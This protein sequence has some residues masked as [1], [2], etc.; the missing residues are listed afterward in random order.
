M[1]VNTEIAVTVTDIQKIADS[2]KQ[3][4]LVR[5]DGK[6]LPVFAPGSHVVVS[7][8]VNGRTHRNPYSL[9]SSSTEQSNYQISVLRT[10]NSRG[11][12]RHLHDDV[13]VGNNLSISHPVDQFPIDVLAKRNLLIAGGVGI[14]PFLPMMEF[15]NRTAKPF[16]LYY[17]IRSRTHGAFWQQLTNLYGNRVRVL[18]GQGRHFDYRSVLVNQ[19]LG[20]HVYICGPRPMLDHIFSIARDLGWADEN[21]HFELFLAPPPGKPF[22]AR[23]AR[24]GI[25]IDVGEHDSFLESIEA[26]GVDAPYLCRGGACGKCETSVV[27][28]DGQLI[29]NDVFLTDDEKAS[30]K[31]IMPCVSRF[32]GSN[33]TIDL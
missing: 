3:F 20:T 14:T 9:I 15:M 25:T 7:M 33:L 1:T 5:N 13:E 29:H 12:S 31:R 19:P 26:A 10:E 2:I 27:V 6:L 11:G 32:T 30:R 17:S 8:S 16:E 22:S 28:A 18:E 23:L 24:S 21:L 4:T